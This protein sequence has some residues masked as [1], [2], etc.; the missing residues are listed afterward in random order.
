MAVQSI[1][2]E[3]GHQAEASRIVENNLKTAIRR[4]HD[5]VVGLAR[6]GTGVN[7]KPPR[8][9]EMHNQD[10]TVIQGHENVLGATTQGRDHT[11]VETLAKAARERNP[12]VGPTHLDTSESATLEVR[13]QPSNDRFN[14]WQFGHAR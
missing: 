12:Q 9:A 8:H 5:M 1:R 6:D 14:F 3:K 11:A 7:K 13:P 2:G 10:L 4:Q